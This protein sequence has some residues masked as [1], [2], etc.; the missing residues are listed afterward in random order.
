MEPETQK[1]HH[2]ITLIP[3][4][5][6]NG[7]LPLQERVKL[8]EFGFSEFSNSGHEVTCPTINKS[9]GFVVDHKVESVVVRITNTTNILTGENADSKG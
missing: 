2:I 5:K 8:E 4:L 1:T 9:F 6:M 3:L 7:I